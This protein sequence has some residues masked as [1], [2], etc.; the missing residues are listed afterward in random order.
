MNTPFSLKPNLLS[1]DKGFSLLEILIAV[2]IVA[3]TF[4]LVGFNSSS[5]RQKINEAYEGIV[6]A[7]EF[8]K[9]EAVIR[10]KVVRI[11]L[12]MSTDPNSYSI[13]AS[14]ESQLTLSEYVDLERLD[15]KE[16]EAYKKKAQSIDSKFTVIEEFKKASKEINPDVS[17]S[18]V[19]TNLSQDLMT[20]NKAY[21]YFYPT[22]FQDESIIFLANYEEIIS[23]KVESV[24]ER[25]TDN[26]YLLGDFLDEN[27]E[28]V[29]YEK[30]KEL[31]DKW[32]EN[33]EF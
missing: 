10:N 20:E 27:Y 16:L 21:I 33:Y 32:S 26:Y 2:A 30:T 15:K 31:Y 9:S 23:I 25:I 24:R 29:V 6:R 28:T 18:G 5:E 17:I 14:S 22:G 12:D 7:I 19:A 13:E 8:S 3:L 1:Q 4:G 11:T